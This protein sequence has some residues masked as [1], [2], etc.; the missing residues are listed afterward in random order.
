M[1]SPHRVYSEACKREVVRLSDESGP[2]TDE[3][4]SDPGI[5]RSALIAWRR[6]FWDDYIPAAVGE[7]RFEKALF[8]LR[9]EK[10]IFRPDRY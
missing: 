3:V 8:R 1:S 4:A 10:S 5:G 2:G 9:R 7:R 6:C